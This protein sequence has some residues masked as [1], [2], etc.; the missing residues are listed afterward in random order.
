MRAQF[1]FMITLQSIENYSKCGSAWYIVHEVHLVR[2]RERE[3]RGGGGGGGVGKRERE[4]DGSVFTV[5]VLKLAMSLHF[6]LPIIG[7]F[8][9]SLATFRFSYFSNGHIEALKF[10]VSSLSVSEKL[11]LLVLT[12]LRWL[13]TVV[14]SHTA[15]NRQAYTPVMSMLQIAV[16]STHC[17]SCN[18]PAH[19]NVIMLY[20][21]KCPLYVVGPFSCRI[22]P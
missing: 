17:T 7:T 2:E 15:S 13:G 12:F 5:V 18:R 10:A 21:V 4:T 8:R 14:T 11:R 19:T 16:Q 1:S 9:F 20:A 22:L 6:P 3:A